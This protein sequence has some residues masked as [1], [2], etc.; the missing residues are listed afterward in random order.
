M[1]KDFIFI[2]LRFCFLFSVFLSQRSKFNIQTQP[3]KIVCHQARLITLHFRT[4]HV[5]IIEPPPPPPPSWA[6]TSP[7]TVSFFSI[8]FSLSHFFKIS[9]TQPNSRRAAAV[10]EQ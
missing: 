2:Y 7:F 6:H 4:Q 8:T 5:H 3:K 10:V 9:P 1:G